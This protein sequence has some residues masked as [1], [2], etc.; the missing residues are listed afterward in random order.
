MNDDDSD[1][2]EELPIDALSQ[3]TNKI[4][5]YHSRNIAAATAKVKLEFKLEFNLEM[6]D[7]Y[8]SA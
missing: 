6:S 7:Q 1:T 3:L 4:E 2:G 8:A 5:F